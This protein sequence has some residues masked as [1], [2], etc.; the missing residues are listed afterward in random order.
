MSYSRSDAEVVDRLVLALTEQ[1]FQVFRDTSGIDPGDNF[2]NT[3]LTQIRR[4]TAIV[5]VISE[6]YSRSRWAQAELY[7]ALTVGKIAI[8]VVLSP[9][10]MTTLDEPVQ[11]L[12]RDTQYVQISRDASADV[13]SNSLVRLLA[14]ART[15]HRWL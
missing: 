5:A 9:G 8:P 3:L 13:M 2:V 7:T 15:R 14:K 4:S 12:V 6:S 11:R 10:S 1:G